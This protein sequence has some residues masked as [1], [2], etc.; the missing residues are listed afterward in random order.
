MRGIDL[1]VSFRRSK[2]M[3]TLLLMRKILHNSND[4]LDE[5]NELKTIYESLKSN[6]IT[7][8]SCNPVTPKL[9][10]T[11]PMFKSIDALNALY[12]LIII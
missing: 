5:I 10:P 6:G 2:L 1:S 11:L 12:K 4:K 3:E 9:L 8:F 7:L